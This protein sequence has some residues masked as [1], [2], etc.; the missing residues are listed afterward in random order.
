MSHHHEYQVSYQARL[1]ELKNI[2][3][4]QE[5]IQ[6]EQELVRR[7]EARERGKKMAMDTIKTTCKISVGA[8][9]A[10]FKISS[11]LIKS[12]IKSTRLGMQGVR[13]V[14]AYI[15]KRRLALEEQERSEIRALIEEYSRI[16]DQSLQ[17]DK[18]SCIEVGFQQVQK[19]H[20]VF[21]QERKNA[22]QVF[23]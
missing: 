1:Q 16:P 10:S 11:F 7:R 2:Q 6:R 15:E 21:M 23:F 13:N 4:E 9:K 17:Q 3:A 8:I 19:E 12:G 5:R 18:K 20:D 14:S 22:H